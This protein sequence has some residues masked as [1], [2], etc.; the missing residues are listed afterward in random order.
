MALY[1]NQYI[2]PIQGLA[3]GKHEI[4]FQIGEGFVKEVENDE[5]H[6]IDVDL[7]LNID[8]TENYYAFEYNL[9]GTVGIECDRCTEVYDQEIDA[10]H[11][12]IIKHASESSEHVEG[13]VEMT[14]IEN[15]V[16]QINILDDIYQYV[17]VSLPF[18][19]V[20]PEGECNKEIIDYLDN[21]NKENEDKI[22]PRWEAL[23]KLKK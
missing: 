23:S 8:K 21:N 3:L 6:R 1:R 4:E 7:K 2:I 12:M 15:G 14:F 19:R 9:K 10:Q 17:M 11:Q 20:H 13:D 5:I 22:D 16:T 18:K